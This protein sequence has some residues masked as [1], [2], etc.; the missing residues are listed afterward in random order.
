MVYLVCYAPS[1]N[2]TVRKEMSTDY[3]VWT[4]ALHFNNVVR[5]TSWCASCATFD[6]VGP[7]SARTPALGITQPPHPRQPGKEAGWKGGS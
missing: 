1:H 2:L 5:I 7:R 3:L 6:L 4:Q